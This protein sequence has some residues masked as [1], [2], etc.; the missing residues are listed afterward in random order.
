MG[1]LRLVYTEGDRTVEAVADT[2]DLFAQPSIAVKRSI[3]HSARGVAEELTTKVLF[4]LSA[5]A[6]AKIPARSGMSSTAQVAR[7][8]EDAFGQRAGMSKIG[9]IPPLDSVELGP[10]EG[11]K[12]KAYRLEDGSPVD[13]ASEPQT[14]TIG[15]MQINRSY[16]REELEAAGFEPPPQNMT[17]GIDCSDP[18]SQNKEK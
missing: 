10:I 3:I 8:L 11:S 18:E 1:S 7:L 12:L 13:L 15:P 6:I 4:A 9:S 5:E 17:V 14:V 16:T 2:A